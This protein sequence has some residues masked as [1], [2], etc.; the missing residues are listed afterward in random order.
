MDPRPQPGR[1]ARPQRGWYTLSVDTLR[2]WAIFLALAGLAG[3]GYL[4]HRY[5]QAYNQRREAGALIAEAG[6]LVERLK[7]SAEL[8]RYRADYDTGRGHL[9]AARRAYG[10]KSFPDAWREG[11]LAR[12][13]LLAVL[14]SVERR[15]DGGEAGFIS[16]HGDVEFRRGESGDWEGARTRVNLASGDYVRTGGNGSAEIM[17]A[18]GTLYTVRPNTSFIVSRGQ[19][20]QGGDSERA[21]AMEYGWVDLNTAGRAARVATPAAEAK[22][23]EDSEAFVGYVKETRQG[24]FG[25]FRGV[26]EVV[27]KGARRRLSGLQEVIQVGERLSEPRP[28]PA[29]PEATAPSDNAQ[30]DVAKAHELVL[31][32]QAVDG[33]AH[34]ALQVSRNHLF[35]DNVI[36]VEDRSKTRA[37]LGLRAAGNFLWRVAAIGRD[38]SLGPWSEPRSFRVT[39]EGDGD[40]APDRQPPKLE[41]DDVTSY[42]NIFIV[43][44]RTDPGSTV[45]VGGEPVKVAA[46]G[47]FTKTIQLNN[48]GWSFIEIRASDAWGHEITKRRRVFVDV[49]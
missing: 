21:I 3:G 18:D 31:G 25:A 23:R 29:R 26:V 27:T 32:W 24:R 48:E 19:G 7:T 47:S 45:T 5:W 10:E 46:D 13:V 1:M 49:P 30:L 15:G 8:D 39:S 37:T 28:L 44:G 6:D 40:G 16:V 42:G 43:G 22:V 4:G 36:D 41:L 33:A 11:A 34:Y 12:N 20:E 14:N 17:F 2:G 38:G 9:Q 35:V